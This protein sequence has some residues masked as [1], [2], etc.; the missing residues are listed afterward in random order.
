MVYIAYLMHDYFIHLFI[1][2]IFFRHQPIPFPLKKSLTK[3]NF[4]SQVELRKVQRNL[5]KK[6]VTNYIATSQPINVKDYIH[7]H[8]TKLR[9]IDTRKTNYYLSKNMPLKII[10][11][12]WAKQDFLT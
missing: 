6:N 7:L 3:Q 5:K 9:D 11:M 12:F 1:H 10:R 2:V 4:G 8:H